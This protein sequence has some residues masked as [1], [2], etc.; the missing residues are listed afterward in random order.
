MSRWVGQPETHWTC[1]AMRWF[2]FL[3]AAAAVAGDDVAGLVQV[4]VRRAPSPAAAA[5]AAARAMGCGRPTR[6]FRPAGIHEA[7]HAAFGLDR[8]FEL[9]CGRSAAA[10]LAKVRA[11]PALASALEAA[12]PVV[13]VAP[14]GGDA[15]D[16]DDVA[17]SG[18]FEPD[19][20]LFGLQKAVLK[21][22]KVPDAWARHGG[23]SDAVVVQVV[24]S[25]VDA[26][27]PDLAD[28][29]WKHPGEV[30]G[31]GVDDDGNGYVDDCRGYNHADDSGADLLGAS[32]HG[33]HCA[34]VV[35]AAS[36]NGLSI[37][38]VA[39]GL[40]SPG[41]RLMTSV[42]F[43]KTRS[44]GY[45]DAIAYGADHGA[46]VCSLSWTFSSPDA[47]NQA[48]LDAIDY[49]VAAGVVV[50]AAAG[51]GGS[52]A[53]WYPA[54]YGPVVAVTATDRDGD[55]A[56]FANRGAWVDVAAPGERVVSTVPGGGVATM[57]GT[58][59]AAPLVAGVVALALATGAPGAAAV[60]CLL[61]TA[62][63]L[64]ASGA[65]AGAVHARRAVRCAAP[66]PSAAPTV[67]V[68]VVHDGACVDSSSWFR[69]SKKG[70]LKTC[71]WAAKKPGKRCAKADDA[72]VRAVDA[73]RAACASIWPNTLACEDR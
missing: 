13:A 11:A 19:D 37:A 61:A 5:S 24:D 3:G 31:N 49:A 50:V 29:L 30:C 40:G 33:T 70:K 7:R 6:V 45:P 72:D 16:V 64:G 39:G 36:G 46:H 12:A 15:D 54:A 38:G 2:A 25:G 10:A 65:G 48:V 68:E 20:P 69:R 62:K 26:A 14:R 9:D 28:A 32:N 73:C 57:T 17:V 35:G 67:D 59:M 21:A 71:A 22:A 53:A 47:Y 60:E 4:K 8:W 51:N 56:S 27:H 66:A 23:G 42:V 34:G 44:R 58:S 43:G 18:G 63:D 1:R 41:A 55:L 52:D